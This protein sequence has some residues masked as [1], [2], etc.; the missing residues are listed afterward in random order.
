MGGGVL[1]GIVEHVGDL[2]HRMTDNIRYGYTGYSEVSEKV[3]KTLRVLENPYGFD[4]EYKENVR[5]NAPYYDKTP[6]QLQ[7]EIDK[8]MKVYTEEHRKLPTYNRPQYM[9]RKAS[10][11]VGEERWDDAITALKEIR[12]MLS[13][14]NIWHKMASGF[15][16]NDDGSLKTF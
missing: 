12:N 7:S 13:D 16:R 10:V 14:P 2:I 6:E 1:S 9:A 5:T 11:A 15:Y 3:Q 4:R 8:A